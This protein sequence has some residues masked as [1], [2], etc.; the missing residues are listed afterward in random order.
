MVRHDASC[1][2]SV[3]CARAGTEAAPLARNATMTARRPPRAAVIARFIEVYPEGARDLF[4][5]LPQ[6][7]KPAG[8]ERLLFP[9]T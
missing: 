1:P 9:I 2:L 7:R 4:S 6:D 3:D 8:I 5:T